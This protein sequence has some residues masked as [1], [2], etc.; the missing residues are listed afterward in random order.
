MV[1]SVLSFA[2]VAWFA[3]LSVGDNQKLEH[4]VEAASKITG[5]KCASKLLRESNI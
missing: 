5:I 2:L 1:E 3:R 4:V